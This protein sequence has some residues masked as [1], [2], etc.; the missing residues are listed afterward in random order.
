MS[1]YGQDMAY[2]LAYELAAANAVIVSGMALGI[3]SVCAAAALEAG[4]T[5]V[6]VLG[7]GLPIA[8]PKEH[9][10]L[11]EMIARRGAVITEYPPMERP[12][13]KNFPRRNRIIS[14]LC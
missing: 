2:R 7:C 1:E 12:N 4:G 13:G 9:T 14:G 3:D 5:T 8:Y 11:M 6:A 10:R